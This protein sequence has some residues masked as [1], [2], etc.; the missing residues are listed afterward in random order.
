[1]KADVLL[2]RIKEFGNSLK[3]LT[4]DVSRLLH[5]QQQNGLG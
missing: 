1:M 2:L 4:K 3:C 5:P